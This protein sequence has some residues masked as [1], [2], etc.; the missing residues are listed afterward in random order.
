MWTGTVVLCGTV[1]VEGVA[2]RW[3]VTDGLPQDLTVSHP[4]LGTQTGPFG[5][6]PD[7]QARNVA[8]AMLGAATGFLEA[9]DDAPMSDGDPEPPIL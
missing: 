6:D 3:S 5:S 2:F 4:M 7:S 9:V 1:V 8:R